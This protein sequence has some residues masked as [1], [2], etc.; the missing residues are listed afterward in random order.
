MKT[1][2]VTNFA[3]HYRAPFFD[4]LAQAID[5]DF[6]FTSRGTEEYWQ[7]HLGTTAVRASAD[8]IVGRDIAAGFRLPSSLVRE[9]WRRDY[10]VLLKCVNGRSELAAAYAVARARRKPFVFW[11]TMWWQ[12]VTVMGWAS[13]PAL[14]G[15]YM[16]S[17]AIVA[18]GEHIRRFIAGQGVAVDKIF[19]AEFAVDNDAFMAPVDPGAVAGLRSGLKA[20]DRPLV[21]AVSRLVPEKGLDVLVAAAALLRD[22]QPLVVVVGTGP[23]AARLKGQASRLGVEL[24]LAGGVPPDRMPVYYEAAD[25]FAM[26]SVTTPAVR[27]PWGLGVNEALCRSTPVVASDAVGATAGGLLVNRETG[28]VVPERDPAALAA[29]LRLLLTDRALAERL[30]AAGHERVKATDYDAM[31]AGFTTAIEYAHRAR[32]GSTP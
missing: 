18:D 17:D 1:L 19:T 6:I 13:Y 11:A 4:R 31:V 20:G 30:A 2:L 16:G 12:P 8:T 25:A 29:A 15:I 3:P 24:R 10:D 14:R 28:L 32:G 7:P 22:L 26:P 9:L 5:V 27:E 21:L 23:L